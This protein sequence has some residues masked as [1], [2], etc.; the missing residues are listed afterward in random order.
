ML[1]LWA[2]SQNSGAVEK[3]ELVL[4]S[5]AFLVRGQQALML[6]VNQV[7]HRS[8]PA[9]AAPQSGRKDRGKNPWMRHY[10]LILTHAVT[11]SFLRTCLKEVKECH[12]I[13]MI[14]ATI[15]HDFLWDSLSHAAIITVVLWQG[16]KLS[17]GISFCC[18]RWQ[19]HQG[20]SVRVM[21]VP[22]IYTA[23]RGASANSWRW[24]EDREPTELC[25]T[26]ANLPEFR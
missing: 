12:P 1:S 19:T 14:P 20:I 13:F 23:M 26:S 4:W 25:D 17:S 24:D 21:C 8:Q 11:K 18:C 16:P 9:A 22:S 2:E 6:T 10:D 3:L 7:L 15:W 5:L